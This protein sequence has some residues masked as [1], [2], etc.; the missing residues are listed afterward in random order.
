MVIDHSSIQ[1]S[2]SRMHPPHI[3]VRFAL[4]H[5]NLLG[6]AQHRQLKSSH[7]R[8]R[9]HDRLLTVGSERIVP[10]PLHL[11]LGISNRIIPDVFSELF[12]KELV[13]E[14]LEK[15]NNSFSHSYSNKFYFF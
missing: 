8:N 4:S 14:T 13:E 5:N 12:S 2:V 3:H 9:T 11:F 1:Y 15:V 7:S 10:T 6:S